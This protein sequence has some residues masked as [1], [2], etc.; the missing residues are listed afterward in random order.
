MR[1]LP[2][3]SLVAALLLASPAGAD[4]FPARPIRMVVSTSAGGITDVCA[5]ILGAFITA[6]AGQTVV[7][8][9]KSGG[10]GNIGMELVAHAAPDGYTLGVANTGN[11]VI[12]PFLYRHMSYDPLSELTPVGSIGQVPLFLIVNGRL[13]VSTLQEFIAYAKARPGQLSYASAG[14]GTTPHLAADAFVRRAGLDIVHVPYHGSVPGVMDVLGGTVQMTFVSMGP[15]MEFVRRGDLRILGVAA[16]ERVPYL[17]AVP[18]FGE[19]G[20]P[21]FTASTWFALFA[22]RGTPA[23]IVEQLNGYVRGLAEDADSVRRLQASFV[24][25]TPLGV[26]AFTAEVKS[27]AEKWQRIVRDSGVSVD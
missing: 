24:D 10:G 13:P 27:D 22:P 6:K 7:I 2:I 17:P 1:Y 4:T 14:T 23:A 18:T 20:L 25:P 11:I 15:H 19:Q 8:D 9:N 5:R 3:V 26:A 16:A 21:G 12:N